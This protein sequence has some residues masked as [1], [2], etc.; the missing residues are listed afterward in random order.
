[1]YVS[2]AKAAMEVSHRADGKTI[3][4]SNSSTL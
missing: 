1:M 4:F 2:C 3:I